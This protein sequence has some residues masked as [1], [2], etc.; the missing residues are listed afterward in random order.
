MRQIYE[1]SDKFRVKTFSLIF[2][3]LLIPMSAFNISA[4]SYLNTFPFVYGLLRSGHLEDF[5]LDMEVPSLCARNLKSG[6]ADIALIPAGAL[7]EIPGYRFISP[8]CLGAVREVKT[9]LLLSEKPVTEIRKIYLDF[10]SMTSVRLVRVLAEKY[11]NIRPEWEPLNPGQAELLV[12]PESLVAIGDKTFALRPRFPYVYDL[13][14]EWIRFTGL[15]FVF[16]V[17][18]ALKPI[19]EEFLLKFND[20]LSYGI[21]HIPESLDF[22]KEKLPSDVDCLEYLTNNIS[23]LLDDEKKKGLELFLGS[24]SQ[25]P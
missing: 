5:R 22:M 11:W 4:V 16:A 9:V 23:Y 7:P 24:I 6:E 15:P 10:D 17:W 18:I 12:K 8:Y 25:V 13:A 21:N 19:P 3:S 14:E 20:A 1:I 2:A